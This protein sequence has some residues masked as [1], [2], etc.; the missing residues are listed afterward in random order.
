MKVTY[1]KLIKNIIHNEKKKTAGLST[2]IENMTRLPV[3]LLLFNVF[4]KILGSALNGRGIGQGAVNME[5][6]S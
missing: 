6:I 4:L 3:S 1:N 2:A 5:K